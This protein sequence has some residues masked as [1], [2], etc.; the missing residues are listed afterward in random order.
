MLKALELAERG[1]LTTW[2]NPWVGCVIVKDNE[3]IGEGFHSLRGQPHAEP[4]A[5]ANCTIDPIDADVYVTLE[6][7]SHYG[8]TPPCCE[9]L[10]RKRV[11]RVFVALE[12]PD[13]NVKGRGIKFLADHGIETFVG[14]CRHEVELSMRPYLHHRKTGKPFVVCKVACGINGGINCVD[15]SSQWITGDEAR[16]DVHKLRA[17]SQA[18]LVGVGTV[19][20]DNPQLTVRGELSTKIKS[21]PLR[22]VIDPSGKSL[23]HPGLNIHDLT[24]A[25][26]LIVTCTKDSVEAD[27]LIKMP[28]ETVDIDELLLNLGKRGILQILVEG[29]AET[30][31]KFI[32][33]DKADLLVI[34]QA[35]KIMSGKNFYTGSFPDNIKDA[36]NWNIE[37]YTPIGYDLKIVL[38]PPRRAI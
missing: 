7:C 21:Q 8:L 13:D 17:E 31:S 25:Q 24:Q 32:S 28:G 26:T 16:K 38:T 4:N 33:Q 29:G 34:Y 22:V 11:K 35:P 10:V 27:N 15:G 36:E 37:A 20:A 5:I 12:D 1:R 9:L 18:V 3:I 30:W 14:L 6:P 19:L 2:S 23:A